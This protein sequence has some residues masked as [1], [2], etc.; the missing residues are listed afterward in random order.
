MN[1][2]LLFILSPTLIIICAS[3]IDG[4][5]ELDLGSFK[6]SVPKE[7]NYK[8]LQGDDSF[9]GD[10]VGPRSA[11]SFDYSTTGYASNLIPTEAEYLKTGRWLIDC[12]LY[13][14]GVTYTAVFNVK[15]EKIRQMKEKGIA[16]SSLVKVEADPCFEAKKNISKPTTEQK[17]KF[18]KADYIATLTYNG[19]TAVLPIQIPSA[20]KNENIKIDTTEKFIIKTVWPKISGQ[21]LTGVCIHSRTSKFNFQMSGKNLS[22]TDQA[23][24]LQ[25]FKTIKLKD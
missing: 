14:P 1:K 8:K 4:W 3:F 21:G 9:I 5:K 18:P 12:P 10:I 19:D 13:K 16:D 25:A 6:I 22:A 20:I 15:N 24:A 23:L 17:N 11:L 7:W 2:K